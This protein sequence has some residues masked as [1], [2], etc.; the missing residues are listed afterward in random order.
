MKKLLGIIVLGLLLSGNANAKNRPTLECVFNDAD[1][2][3]TIFD[4]NK[5]GNEELR[6]K[7]KIIEKTFDKIKQN[8][9]IIRKHR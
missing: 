7:A 4:L 8:E 6:P 5:Y 1:K 3:T 2:T 9:R